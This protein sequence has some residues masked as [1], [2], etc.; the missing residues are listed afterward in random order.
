[1]VNDEPEE[2]WMA[3]FLGAG[4][5]ET[6]DDGYEAKEIL[7]PDEHGDDVEEGTDKE[8][9]PLVDIMGTN[10]H[11]DDNETNLLDESEVFT[12]QTQ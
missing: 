4:E 7:L 2:A 10:L 1:M 12:P 8:T 9:N 6:E 3:I 5:A 11:V